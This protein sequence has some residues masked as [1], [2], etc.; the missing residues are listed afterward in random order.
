MLLDLLRLAKSL[1]KYENWWKEIKLF[2][3]INPQLVFIFMF[4]AERAYNKLFSGNENRFTCF[5]LAL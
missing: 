3:P 1:S 2:L 5:S 4:V